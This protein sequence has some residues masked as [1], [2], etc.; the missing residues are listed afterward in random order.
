[1]NMQARAGMAI[2]RFTHPVRLG[3][4]AA[5]LALAASSAQAIETLSDE[6]LSSV[7]AQDGIGL[8]G[9][10]QFNVNAGAISNLSLGFNVGGSTSYLVFQQ[11]SG[12]LD[13]LGLQVQALSTPA[14]SAVSDVIA[15]TLPTWV[16]FTNFGVGA[17][18]AQTSPTAPI[19]S[20]LGQIQLNGSMYLTGQVLLWPK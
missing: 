7:H 9:H 5:W 13:F 10:L 18:A 6:D 4:A 3:L 14:G 16:G 11:F 12:T 8:S 17:I 1:M 20:S 2:G 15:I 19:T